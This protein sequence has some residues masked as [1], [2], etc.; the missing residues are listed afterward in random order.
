MMGGIGSV[1]DR[2]G[3]AAT[4]AAM[5]AAVAARVALVTAAAVAAIFAVVV[6]VRLVPAAHVPVR[7]VGVFRPT[8]VP[9]VRVLLPL[10]P[11]HPLFLR[12]RDF[13]AH[14][15]LPLD[16]LPLVLRAPLLLLVMVSATPTRHRGGAR[17]V[18]ADLLVRRPP[19]YELPRLGRVLLLL[20]RLCG[21]PAVWSLAPS[22][23]WLI[24]ADGMANQVNV[25]FFAG[26]VALRPGGSLRSSGSRLFRSTMRA[27]ASGLW[28]DAARAAPLPGVFVLPT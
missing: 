26:S 28:L 1:S 8:C 3:A 2:H 20:Q 23:S 4:A 16:L 24:G 12:L 9:Q 5:A 13:L 19:L 15:L 10:W 6:L 17:H 7:G 22:S 11:H 27:P 14:L 21:P 18:S 25:L